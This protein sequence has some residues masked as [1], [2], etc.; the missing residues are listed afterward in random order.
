[1]TFQLDSKDDGKHECVTLRN[2]EWI[3]WRC[4]LCAGYER[5]Y[6][7]RTGKMRVKGKGDAEHKAKIPP[8]GASG[9]E[10]PT[11]TFCDN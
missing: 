5:R 1:M 3:V 10:V 9:E 2:G 8:F 6:N 7:I 4:P 11:T